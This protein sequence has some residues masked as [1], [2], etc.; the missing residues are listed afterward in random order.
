MMRSISSDQVQA[1]VQ[2]FWK[3]FSG[4]DKSGFEQLY[5]PTATVFAADARRSEPA[6]LMFVR[7]E[8][9]LFG[10]KSLVKAQLGP[11]TV[12]LLAPDLASAVYSFHFSVTRSLPNGNRTHVD[13]P[14]GRA[15]QV[16]QRMEDGSLLIIHEHMSS[17]EAVAP[18]I[19]AAEGAGAS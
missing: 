17:A 4:K 1:Q 5:A 9:E 2:T 6:R 3:L 13:V 18:K 15:T 10:P 12:Q 7:R 11:I 19:L 14:H 8:R 16:F